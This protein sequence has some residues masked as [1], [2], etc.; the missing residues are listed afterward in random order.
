MPKKILTAN[1]SGSKRIGQRRSTCSSKNRYLCG[2]KSCEIC[3]A[4]SF[5]THPRSREWADCNEKKSWQVFISSREKYYLECKTCRHTYLTSISHITCHN[6]GC[7]YCA[8][9][10]LCKNDDCMICFMNSFAFHPSSVEWADCN[11]D[12]PRD[13][14]PNC[15]KKNFSAA[16]NANIYTKHRQKQLVLVMEVAA[17]VV[18]IYY[19]T[20][21]VVS[22]VSK[23]HL[24]PINYLKDGVMVMI[25]PPDKYSVKVL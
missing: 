22:H 1:R 9:K 21:M 11:D 5:A 15:K 25:K 7:P 20:M 12:L 3:F 19:V 17:I 10:L 24:R 2:V 6:S 14:F 18:V 23:N 13:I 16:Q 8:H 4:R